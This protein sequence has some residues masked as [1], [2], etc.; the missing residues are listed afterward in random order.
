MALCEAAGLLGL[1]LSH[2]PVFARL[3]EALSIQRAA[4]LNVC[5]QLI[6]VAD[7]RRHHFSETILKCDPQ[8]PWHALDFR[9]VPV[10]PF[11]H[12]YDRPDADRR[13]I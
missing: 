12:S 9:Y 10:P 5:A 2:N 1:S 8:L 7:E 4:D 3:S 11:R 13:S 6:E